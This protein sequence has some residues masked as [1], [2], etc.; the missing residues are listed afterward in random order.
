MWLFGEVHS[1]HPCYSLQAQFNVDHSTHYSL[2]HLSYADARTT[3]YKCGVYGQNGLT[4]CPHPDV[5]TNHVHSLTQKDK[6]ECYYRPDNE[7]HVY[8]E[9]GNGWAILLEFLCVSFGCIV[10]LLIVSF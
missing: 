3:G 6:L 4:G 2:L 1:S 7:H 5:V 9:T 10:F 8:I